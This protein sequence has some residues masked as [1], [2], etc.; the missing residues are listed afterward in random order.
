MEI[1]A[2]S[3]SVFDGNQHGGSFSSKIEPFFQEIFTLLDPPRVV[4][5]LE[6]DLIHA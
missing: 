6:S 5:S 4:H 2:L 3:G 1:T